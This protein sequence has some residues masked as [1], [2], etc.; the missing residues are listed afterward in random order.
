LTLVQKPG[1][2]CPDLI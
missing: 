2:N 1:L